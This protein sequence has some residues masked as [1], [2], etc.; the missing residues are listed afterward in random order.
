M[1]NCLLAV[2]LVAVVLSI[3][4]A[5]SGEASVSSDEVQR[6]A[7]VVLRADLKSGSTGE[8]AAKI[9]QRVTRVE[10]VWGTRGDGGKHV[11]VYGTTDVT[12][13]QARSIQRQLEDVSSVVSVTQVR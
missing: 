13:E 11:W 1:R 4:A 8:T 10:G 7:K 5:C 3:S 12:P 2:A 6:D 9:V